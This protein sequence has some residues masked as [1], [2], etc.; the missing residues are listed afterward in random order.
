[1]LV[2]VICNEFIN[3]TLNLVNEYTPKYTYINIRI[4]I[5]FSS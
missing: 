3:E 5:K 4:L 1:M 2:V